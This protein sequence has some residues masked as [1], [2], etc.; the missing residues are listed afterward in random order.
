MAFEDAPEGSEGKEFYTDGPKVNDYLHQLHVEALGNADVLTVGEMSATSV[1]KC[2]GYSKPENEELSMCFNFHHLKVD[3]K[4]KQKWTLMPFDFQEL[5]DLFFEW[6]VKMEEEGGWN[7]LFWNCHDQ[8]RAL[9]R[10]GDPVHYPKESAKMLASVIFTRRGTPYFLYG[11]EIGMTN[12]NSRSVADYDDVESHN[13]ADMLKHEQHKSDDEILAILQAK[14]ATT[15]VRPCSGRMGQTPGLQAAS[16]GFASTTISKPSMQSRFYRKKT[17]S[18]T[19]TRNSSRSRKQIP[20][21]ST[22]RP[23]RSF[24]RTKISTPM[25]E[26]SIAKKFYASTIF[27]DTPL[28][29]ARSS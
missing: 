5:K 7:A 23:E 25:C 4:D 22:E 9:S 12:L 17:P 28:P 18:M 11:D 10:F 27:S 19:T 16:P 2:S 20:S 15:A 26:N 29:F 24:K 8:P 14:A 21:C 6:D 1:E 13:A 3:Y